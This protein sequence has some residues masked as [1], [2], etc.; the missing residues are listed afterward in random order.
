MSGAV[1]QSHR[2]HDVMLNEKQLYLWS[3]TT[4]GRSMQE[5]RLAAR[6]RYLNTRWTCGQIHA[7]ALYPFNRYNVSNVFYTASQYSV[8]VLLLAVRF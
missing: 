8:V 3:R 4:F 6:I 5:C 1:L 7:Q 2:R